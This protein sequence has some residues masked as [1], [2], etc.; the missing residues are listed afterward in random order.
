MSQNKNIN[1][2]KTTSKNNKKK[3]NG[4]GNG[5]KIVNPSRTVVNYVPIAKS[6][7]IERGKGA[8]MR[9][10]NS[11][12][13][14]FVFRGISTGATYNVWS[15]I[16][17]AARASTF[18]WLSS[19]ANHYQYYVI[20]SLK[21]HYTTSSATTVKGQIAM[22]F[23]YDATDA[24]SGS[25][26]ELMQ[27][28]KA[29]LGS[30]Y[31]NMTLSV[32]PRQFQYKKYYV[33]VE[34]DSGLVVNRIADC[35]K[36]VIATQGLE[37][38][39]VDGTVKVEYDITLSVTQRYNPELGAEVSTTTCSKLVPT[40]G[41]KST[42]NCLVTDNTT[43]TIKNLQ[44]F[45]VMVTVTGVGVE[46]LNYNTFCSGLGGTLSLTDYS[47]NTSANHATILY[48]TNS[49]F[50]P[51]EN[52]YIVFDTSLITSLTALAVRIASY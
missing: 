52:L 33:N 39:K 19:I 51:Y 9:I 1:K 45:R 34:T 2:K 30:V 37:D 13:L 26:V 36:I 20:N 42:V 28:E 24:S 41:M 17:N 6:S 15:N 46:S 27:N 14:P 31:R 44:E 43:L 47:Y 25:M 22:Y 10:K 5:K 7:V 8:T 32:D 40:N 50:T 12:L 18:P 23:D 4:N 21:F 35:G 48:V 49:N 11:E 3:K 29:M 38:T 16:I